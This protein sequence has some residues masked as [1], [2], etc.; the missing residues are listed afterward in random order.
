[1]L[2]AVL[3]HYVQS[4]VFKELLLTLMLFLFLFYYNTRLYYL[5]A[6][7]P[8]YVLEEFISFIESDS[9]SYDAPCNSVETYF[10]LLPT[11]QSS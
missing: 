10:S 6:S 8:L 2:A 3:I 1:M 4:L 9:S 11:A 7:Q 5:T